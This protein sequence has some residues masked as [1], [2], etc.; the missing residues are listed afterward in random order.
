MPRILVIEDDRELLHGLRVNLEGN[1][2][3][4]VTAR[5]GEQGVLEAV[6]HTPDVIILDLMMPKLS[7]FEVCR[8]LRER[9][10][11]VPIVI[12]TARDQERDKI[13]GFGLGADDYLT[14]PFSIQE[15]LARLRA[16]IRR[17]GS[18][19]EKC[20]SYRSDNL[21]IDFVGQ[22]LR[23]KSSTYGLSHLEV[24]VLHYL[25]ARR[26]Q[27]VRREDLLTAIWGYQAFTTRAVDNLVARLRHKVETHPHRPRH[28]LSI[29]GV[30]YKF[31]G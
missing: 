12:L 31:V 27:V 21:E 17:A 15:L 1:G 29:Y 9:G 4:V 10:H 25:I 11:Q 19:A 6:R 18:Q 24:E 14:K 8:Q 3:E 7:G 28:I 16:V 22:Q 23:T 5:N 26:G 13:R 20:E 2:F 30:G